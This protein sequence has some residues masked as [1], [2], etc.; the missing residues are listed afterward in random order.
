[1]NYVEKHKCSVLKNLSIT[2][3]ALFIDEFMSSLK[4]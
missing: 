3:V 4:I 2:Y 1:M